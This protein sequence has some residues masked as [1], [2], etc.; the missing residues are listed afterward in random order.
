[1]SDDEIA[2]KGR[3][4]AK[5]YTFLGEVLG[6]RGAKNTDKAVAKM[7]AALDLLAPAG[8]TKRQVASLIGL[9]LHMA[10][11]LNISLAQH[12]DMMRAYSRLGRQVGR[13]G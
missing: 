9:M 5:E 11:T 7:E 1:M 6:H 10:H 2:R 4:T 13:R 8:R 3:E 12:F